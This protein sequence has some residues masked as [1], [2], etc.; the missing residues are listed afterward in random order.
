MATAAAGNEGNGD[1]VACLEPGNVLSDGSDNAG[2]FV[3]RDMRQAN[4]RIVAH[5]AMPVAAAEARRLHLDDHAVVGRFRIRQGCHNRG[6]AE[7]FVKS[8]RILASH[9]R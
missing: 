2:E 4:I 8:A 9:R 3:A 5:P 7:Q 6:L 1:T